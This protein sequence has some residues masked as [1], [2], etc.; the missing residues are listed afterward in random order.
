[1]CGESNQ[2]PMTQSTKY[3]E[4]SPR[5]HVGLLQSKKINRF[6]RE[7]GGVATRGRPVQRRVIFG[8]FA[9][10]QFASLW[11]ENVL[12]FHGNVHSVVC[13]RRI[14]PC[15]SSVASLIVFPA[16]LCTLDVRQ[17]LHHS[18]PFYRTKTEGN[19]RPGQESCSRVS[20]V[21]QCVSLNA[22]HAM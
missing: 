4:T 18:R 15:S 7:G 10:A 1:M 12:W 17:N 13:L 5:A 9:H 20:I 14:C 3:R 11:L 16:Y 6:E 2:G 8:F 22:F 19:S 21:M